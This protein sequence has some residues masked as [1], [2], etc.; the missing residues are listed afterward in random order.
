[1]AKANE[2]I[3]LNRPSSKMFVTALYAIYDSR[4]QSLCVANAGNP[5]PVGSGGKIEAKGVSLGVLAKMTYEEQTVTLKP[6]DMLVLYSDGAE[7]A[8]NP[9]REQFGEERV[10]Q[11][12][13]ENLHLSPDEIQQRLLSEIHDFTGDGP[14]F[15]D[16][17]LVTLKTSA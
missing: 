4:D 6:G 16:I 10:E 11:I 3:Y 14:P 15:D 12:I 5:F 9:E 2:L 13:S 8:M 7:D 1:M 17:T